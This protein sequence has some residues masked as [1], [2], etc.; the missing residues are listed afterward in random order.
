M[1]YDFWHG[2][3]A[4][5]RYGRVL[6]NQFEIDSYAK[7]LRH[8]KRHV[9]ISGGKGTVAS[10]SDKEIDSEGDD[11]LFYFH[12]TFLPLNIKITI[13]FDFEFI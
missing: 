7:T 9:E 11:L 8:F 10:D 3:I 13:N 1:R 12:N 4:Y 6:S 5:P 2:E